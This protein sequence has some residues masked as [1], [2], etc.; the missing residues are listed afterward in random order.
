M[1]GRAAAVAGSARRTHW[2]AARCPIM[3]TPQP[4]STE[5]AVKRTARA[6]EQHSR[7]VADSAAETDL[8]VNVAIANGQYFGGGMKIAPDASPNDGLFDVI[9]MHDLTRVQVASFSP[10]VYQGTHLGQPGVRF[11]QGSLIEA[12]S[13]LPHGEVL[14][15]M[16]G[17]TPGRLPLV[18]RVARGALKIRA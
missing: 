9:A 5:Q 6:V 18:A 16:D 1:I 14:I 13:L 4:K 10:R 11:A 12:E 8:L 7:K 17:E 3:A 2:A 15:D